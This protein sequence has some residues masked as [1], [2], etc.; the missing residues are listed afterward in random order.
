MQENYGLDVSESSFR[1]FITKNDEFNNYFLK[2]KAKSAGC[3]A[4]LRYE[5]LKG[6]QAQID[7]KES[8]TLKL[9]EGTNITLNIFVYVLSHS[10]FKVYLV[11]ESKLQSIL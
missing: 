10:R 2:R 7:W 6:D 5:T 9:K 1:R 11:S 3:P 8:M 4:L